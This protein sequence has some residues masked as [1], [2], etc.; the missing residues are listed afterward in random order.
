MDD[1]KKDFLQ[2]IGKWTLN[3]GKYKGFTYEEVKTK[4]AA[5]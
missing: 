5:Y 2:G 4:D 3:F 1:I